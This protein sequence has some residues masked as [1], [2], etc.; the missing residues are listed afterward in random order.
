MIRV[1]GDG[2]QLKE[3]LERL[4]SQLT[5][6]Q[7]TEVQVDG[8]P[9]WRIQ[10]DPPIP[11]I[12][13][14]LGGPYLVLGI[15][16]GSA[17]EVMQ[18]ARTPV[19]DWLQ[20]ARSK[21]SVPRVASFGY[22]DIERIVELGLQAAGDPRSAEII[23]ALG[24]DKIKNVT[25]VNGLDELGCIT[26]SL[27]AVD[28]KGTGI[29]SWIDGTPLAADELEVVSANTPA[30]VAFKLDTR[31]VFDVWMETVTRLAPDQAEQMS[32]N[33]T[34][35]E[36]QLGFE[37]RDD[38]LSSLGDAWRIFV[39]PSGGLVNGWTLAIE[40]RNRNRLEQVQTTLLEM[41]QAALA[42]APEGGPT[43]Q[44]SGQGAYTIRTLVLPGVP[45]TPSW[46]LTDDELLVTMTPDV[47]RQLL[48]AGGLRTFADQADVQRMVT[49]DSRTLGLAFINTGAVVKQLLPMAR[50]G[51]QALAAQPGAP[52]LDTSNLPPADAIVQHLQPTRM[53]LRRTEDGIEMVSHQTLPGGNGGAITGLAVGLTLPAVASGRAAAQRMQGVNNLKQIVLGMHNYHDAYKA[54]PASH[55]ADAE[56]EPLLSW[57]VHLLPFID[58]AALY[59]QFRLD[60]PWDS[61]HNKAL[62]EQ[63]PAV[64]RS[65]RSKG[66][67]GMTHYLGVAGADG[68][69]VSPE[70]GN[71]LGASIRTIRDGT[72][73]TIA[74]IEVPDETAVV[75]TKPGDFS[76]DADNPIRGL[77]GLHP[78]GFQAALADGSIRFFAEQVDPGLLQAMFTK[79]GAEPVALP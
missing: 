1:D 45:F 7:V 57:R 25:S 8:R 71:N 17:E 46:C 78:G 2:A 67:P 77:L 16:D 10:F 21:L 75:W 49:R 30:V 13:W 6:A 68:V 34:Q 43:L 11:P 33:L 58:Q 48:T 50:M 36:D 15:G 26:R 20:S 53:T 29:L 59:E 31:D 32:T 51:L 63:M 65:P 66:E 73:N 39:R 28:G 42:A 76:P 22:V 79:A 18:R 74:I 38:V 12:T 24:V 41:A 27:V 4:Q 72:S 47:M 61:P 40:V 35:L 54:F 3:R 14:G 64:Y 70:P 44:T 37:I 19:P 60:E 55:S 52:P 5:E 62:I 69:F 23:A 9:F 56:G